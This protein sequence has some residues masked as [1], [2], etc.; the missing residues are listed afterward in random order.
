MAVLETT[1]TTLRSE[2]S[3]AHR[4]LESERSRLG[5]LREEALSAA[6][7]AASREGQA[8]AQ[9]HEWRERAERLARQLESERER[10]GQLE[11]LYGRE[12]AQM[13]ERLR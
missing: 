13:D 12:R 1:V 10:I 11:D 8:S 2:L 9:E 3:S 7:E 4:S 5:M 6:D